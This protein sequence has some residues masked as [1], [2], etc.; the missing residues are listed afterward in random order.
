[1]L[2]RVKDAERESAM[3]LV[4]DLLRG[5]EARGSKLVQTVSVPQGLCVV[6]LINRSASRKLSFL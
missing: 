6:E 2:D 4:M 1:M 3:A 5:V